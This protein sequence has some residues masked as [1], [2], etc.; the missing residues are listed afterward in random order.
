MSKSATILLLD[1]CESVVLSQKIWKEHVRNHIVQKI[2]EDRAT[3][4]LGVTFLNSSTTD[5]PLVDVDSLESLAVKDVEYGGIQVKIPLQKAQMAHMEACMDAHELPSTKGYDSDYLDAIVVAADAIIALTDKK[6]YGE[7]RIILISDLSNPTT[8]NDTGLEDIQER[9][10]AAD[11]R[12][13]VWHLQGDT[14]SNSGSVKVLKALVTS[15]NS[16]VS[17]LTW[18]SA[19]PKIHGKRVRQ[20]AGFK[21]HLTLADG[22]F[23]I[24][25]QVY[26]KTTSSNLLGF[27]RLPWDESTQRPYPKAI[28]RSVAYMPSL[29][30]LTSESDIDRKDNSDDRRVVGDR[31]D[32][33]KAYKY[34][35]SLIPFSAVDEEHMAFKAAKDFSIIGFLSSSELSPHLFLGGVQIVAASLGSR[36]ALLKM[37][38][39]V[40]VL[41][42]KNFG[43]LA[44]QVLRDD[45]APR[46]VGLL[47]HMEDGVECLLLAQLPFAEDFRRYPFGPISPALLPTQLQPSDSQLQ[48]MSSF[49][50]AMDLDDKVANGALIFDPAF[51]RQIQCVLYRLENPSA[52]TIASPDPA[53]IEP[54]STPTGGLEGAS[55]QL[56]VLKSAFPLRVPARKN[57]FEVVRFWSSP[58]AVD[59]QRLKESELGQLRLKDKNLLDT[60]LPRPTPLGKIRKDSVFGDYISM[61]TNPHYD[62]VSDAMMQLMS[63]V[64]EFVRTNNI[65]DAL[66]SIQELC[67]TA[68]KEDEF[69]LYNEFLKDM[70]KSRY[71]APENFPAVLWRRMR[72]KGLS[73]ISVI[74]NPDSTV[75]AM[76]AIEFFE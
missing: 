10:M 54:L 16:S 66:R 62:L 64:P 2:L 21:G 42:H 31:K 68:I 75:S 40:E 7:K 23:A 19:A 27:S 37:K 6:K 22:S 30:A 3:D 73:L 15:L 4:S 26:K 57:K 24:N 59:A 28:E 49:V 47:P 72:D 74:D 44:R 13:D 29:S 11:I 58:E 18:A 25:V 20:T 56:S 33:I 8:I 39:L 60:D 55:A 35:R 71:I 50:T 14:A 1:V 51:Q 63:M 43:I 45:G 69:D 9:L 46:L 34:G 52:S 17:M 70:K 12:L 38:S 76:E 67:T 53:L 65:K 41:Q 36:V 5:N 48:E 32:L 61:V